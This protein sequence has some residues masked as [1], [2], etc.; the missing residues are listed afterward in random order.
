MWIKR[1]VANFRQRRAQRYLWL[2][3]RQIAKGR[4]TSTVQGGAQRS[5]FAVS[6]AV[7]LDKAKNPIFWAA[8]NNLIVFRHRS[9]T[10]FLLLLKKEGVFSS[11]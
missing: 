5:D 2:T 9:K 10:F 4:Y 3:L 6:N 11:A 8:T 1:A 7:E